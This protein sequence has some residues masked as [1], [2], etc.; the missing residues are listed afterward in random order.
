MTRRLV[1][2]ILS[3]FWLAIASGCGRSPSTTFYTLTAQAPEAVSPAAV[4]HA[5]AVGPVTLPDLIDRPQ[6]VIRVA[7][8]RV[9][10]L[11]EHRWAEPLKSQISRLLAEDLARLMR[12]ARVSVFDQNIS[13]DPEYRVLVDIQRFE[14]VPGEG[15]TIEALWSVHRK[16]GNA[17]T[18]RGHSLIRQKTEGSSYDALVAAYSRALAEVSNDIAGALRAEE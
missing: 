15:V 1:A 12:P 16:S 17:V 6:L 5:V 14:S 13:Q 9:D 2:G 10:I 8:N 11:E 7:A 3:L 4:P 18:R